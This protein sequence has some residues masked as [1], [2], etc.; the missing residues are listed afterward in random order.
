MRNSSSFTEGVRVSS[1]SAARF[2]ALACDKG[3]TISAAL[4]E[5][6][7]QVYASVGDEVLLAQIFDGDRNSLA[8]LFRRYA[9]LVHGIGR[10]ILRDDAEAQDLVQDVFLHIA[11]K[12]YLFDSSK[13]S[14]R[15]WIVQMTY[16]QAL[17]RKGYLT[18]R[19]YYTALDCEGSP[20]EELAT[21]VIAEYDH[22]GE[23]LFGRKRWQRVR[24]MLT[25]DQWETIRL[26]FF[27]GCTFAEIG[28]RRNQPVGNVRNHFYRGLARLRKYLFRSELQ[29]C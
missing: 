27:E 14:A 13:G 29:G 4:L 1:S 26:H 16:F 3:G 22:S 20:A 19:H 18:E 9:R 6:D 12:C 8:V 24:E 2:P 15:S 10:R 11:R 23:A 28:E 21:P 7:V 17:N 5:R 25:E